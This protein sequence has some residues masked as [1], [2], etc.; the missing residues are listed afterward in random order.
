MRSLKIKADKQNPMQ[1]ERTTVSFGNDLIKKRSPSEKI[2]NNSG[3]LRGTK[4]QFY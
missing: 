2:R 1:W 4:I 3:K